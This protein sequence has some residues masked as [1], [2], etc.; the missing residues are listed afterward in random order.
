ME[1]FLEFLGVK[2]LYLFFW[3]IPCVFIAFGLGLIHKKKFPSFFDRC[4][5][6]MLLLS[7]TTFF[8][9]SKGESL[10]WFSDKEDAI[11]ASITW[12]GCSFATFFIFF[13]ALLMVLGLCF[14]LE[15]FGMYFSWK[16]V[17]G[18]FLILYGL[19]SIIFSIGRI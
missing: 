16:K 10:L 8:I 15:K 4:V 14:L 7:S 11:P 18:V 13:D 19:S 17:W 3:I 1:E 5:G 6:S 2:L 9:M 12:T